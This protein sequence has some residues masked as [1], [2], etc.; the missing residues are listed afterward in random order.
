[1]TEGDAGPNTYESTAVVEV[2]RREGGLRVELAD[3]WNPLRSA[4]LSADGGAWQQLNAVDGLLDGQREVLLED[5]PSEARLL[6]LRVTDAAFNT[7]TFDLT[8]AVR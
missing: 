5:Q 1:M 2:E 4:E 3:A 7:L 6:L 8:R